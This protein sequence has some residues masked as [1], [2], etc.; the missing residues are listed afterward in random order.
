MPSSALQR[1]EEHCRNPLKKRMVEYLCGGRVAGDKHRSRNF[2]VRGGRKSDPRRFGSSTFL[3]NDVS[4][5]RSFPRN[6]VSS[7]YYFKD[8]G[9]RTGIKQDGKQARRD[10]S[11]MGNPKVGRKH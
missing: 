3:K 4:S 5:A 11:T 8:I 2:E 9:R 1:R 6:F 7:E 10:R